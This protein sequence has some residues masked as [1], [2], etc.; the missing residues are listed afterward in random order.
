[1]GTN[2]LR[3]TGSD[4]LDVIAHEREG[5]TGVGEPHLNLFRA[6]ELTSERNEFQRRA[7]PYGGLV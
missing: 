2:T 6:V 7:S 1:M 4:D 3:S 5:G